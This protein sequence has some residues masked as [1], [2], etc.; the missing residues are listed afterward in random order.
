MSSIG[1]AVVSRTQGRGSESR[2]HY[3]NLNVPLS[4]KFF[5]WDLYLVKKVVYD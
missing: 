1:R 5:G 2:L 4:K 3:S